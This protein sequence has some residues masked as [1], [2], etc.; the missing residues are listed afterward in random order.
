[1]TNLKAAY[2]A[3]IEHLDW[4]GDA[5]RAEALKKLD[6]YVIKVGY[7]DRPRDYSKVVIRRD[8]IVADVR[9]AAAYEW[10]FQRRPQQR[11]GRSRRL[12]HDA[13][14]Q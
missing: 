4:M 13:P 9:A 1:M 5:T 14:D 12:G 2:R 11:T 6:T 10:G 7:P 8:D 3:R